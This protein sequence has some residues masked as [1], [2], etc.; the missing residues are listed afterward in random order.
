MQNGKVRP[1]VSTVNLR[2]TYK[3]PLAKSETTPV[4][5]SFVS[6][7]PNGELDPNSQKKRVWEEYSGMYLFTFLFHRTFTQ[8]PFTQFSNIAI[9]KR[10]SRGAWKKTCKRKGGQT[11]QGSRVFGAKTTPTSCL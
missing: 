9:C 6:V 8:L 4:L 2:K 1:K 3:T 7:L 5:E 10:Y 11:S